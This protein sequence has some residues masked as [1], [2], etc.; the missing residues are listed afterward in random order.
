MKPLRPLGMVS[1]IFGVIT[2]LLSIAGAVI[3][4]WGSQDAM[5]V[6]IHWIGEERVL[7]QQNVL[8]QPDGSKLL[9]NPGAMA[10]I[11]VLIWVV[12]LSQGIAG[13]FLIWKSVKV[14][15]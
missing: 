7:G 15:P 14:N 6:V 5:L 8:L 9:T 13:G 3:L 1:I 10:K 11:A 4:I 12:G 2:G